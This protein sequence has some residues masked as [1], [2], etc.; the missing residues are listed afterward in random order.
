MALGE[1][2]LSISRDAYR[3]RRCK[4][5]HASVLGQSELSDLG[6]HTSYDRNYQYVGTRGFGQLGDLNTRI[7]LLLDGHRINDNIYDAASVGRGLPVDINMIERVEI[8]LGPS[9][10]MYGTSAFFSVVNVI[11]KK[12]RDMPADACRYACRRSLRRGREVA[13]CKGYE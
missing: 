5:L 13:N 4:N 3:Y 2:E 7:L 6:F 11:T 12:G 10:A 1:P 9:S 8:I